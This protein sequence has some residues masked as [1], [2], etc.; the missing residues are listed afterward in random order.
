MLTAE[1]LRSEKTL[2]EKE[3]AAMEP[4][5]KRLALVS[6][7]LELYE[8]PLE[9]KNGVVAKFAGLGTTAGVFAFLNAQPLLFFTPR[10]IAEALRAGGMK[11]ESPNFSTSVS[12]ICIRAAQGRKL[13]AGQKDGKAAYRISIQQPI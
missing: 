3:L 9:R 1:M 13:E 6:E 11:N 8:D 5:R 2:L 12:T 4:K 7:L 10:E